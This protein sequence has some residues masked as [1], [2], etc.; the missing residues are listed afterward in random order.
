MKNK[1]WYIKSFNFTLWDV[2]KIHKEDAEKQIDAMIEKCSINT[3]TFAFAALQ[4]HCY[5]TGIDWKGPDMLDDGL[6]SGLIRYAQSKNLKVILKPMVNVRD[7]Y[8]RAY[9]RFFDEEV[10]C[11][12]KWKDWFKNYAEYITHYAK[13]CEKE[14]VDLLMI[15]CELVGTDHRQNEWRNLVKTVRTVYS[16]LITYNCDKYQEHNVAWWDV[17]DAISSS[18]YYPETDW[19]H[20]IQRI[21]SVVRKYDKPFFFS[22][23][24]CPSTHDA[25]LVPNDWTVVG[26]YPTDMEEQNNFFKRIFQKCDPLKWHYGHSI[27][28][29]TAHDTSGN[30]SATDGSYSVIDKPAQT[31]IKN[32]F[33]TKDLSD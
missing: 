9:I 11:E 25:A 32:Y 5:S 7:G 10:P 31:T 6:F 29:W 22:E 18:G 16:G 14:S 28:E 24:G 19:D 27:W 8:W 23:V 1:M 13:L 4:D 2:E 21:E 30:S 15:G 3:V 33:S 20:Q 17:L 26:K 12:P